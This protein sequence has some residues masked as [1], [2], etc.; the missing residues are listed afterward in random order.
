MSILL[1][2]ADQDAFEHSQKFAIATEEELKNKKIWREKLR[3]LYSPL[4][5][6][7]ILQHNFNTTAK[8]PVE[9]FKV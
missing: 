8:R 7:S 5:N 2:M 6:I 9:N 4:E 1:N 3:E